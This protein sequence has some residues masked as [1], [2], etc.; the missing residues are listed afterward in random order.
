MNTCKITIFWPPK[1]FS[2]NN[3]YAWLSRNCKSKHEIREGV[4]WS[5]SFTFSCWFAGLNRNQK[6]YY[7]TYYQP[8]CTYS[9]FA[10]TIEFLCTND[11]Y[12]SNP[13]VELTI[14][15]CWKPQNPSNLKLNVD[16]SA[17]E[18]LGRGRIGGVLKDMQGEWVLGFHKRILWTTNLNARMLALWRGLPLGSK[19]GF[20]RL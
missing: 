17:K 8:L 18:N 12:L 7:P 9:C 16:G 19:Y 4:P 15:V 11:L 1:F 10:Q 3:I 6:I 14:K 20:Q 2:E 13:R 5:S